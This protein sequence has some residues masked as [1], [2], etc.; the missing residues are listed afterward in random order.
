MLYQLEQIL[1]PASY[2]KTPCQLWWESAILLG[3]LIQ[4]F[5]VSFFIAGLAI[6]AHL[7][8]NSNQAKFRRI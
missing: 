3:V 5:A 8:T 6:R 1:A 4:G 2:G 7:R